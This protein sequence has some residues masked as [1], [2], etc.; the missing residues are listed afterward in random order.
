MSEETVPSLAAA[1]PLSATGGDGR[2]RQAA[3][4]AA[5][6][7]EVTPTSLVAYGSAGRLA[8]LGATAAVSR[9]VERLMAI[10][11]ARVLAVSVFLTDAEAGALQ[12]IQ[13]ACPDTRIVH[14]AI[15]RVEGHL[16]AFS[17]FASVDGEP[18]QVAP[19][20]LTANQGFDL[21][22]DLNPGALVEHPVAP[23]GYLWLAAE[24]LDEERS[25]ALLAQLPEL[26]GEFHKPRYFR[27]DTGICAHA[28]RGLVGCSACLQ[29]CPTGAIASIDKRIE[30]DPY[31]CQ[32]GGS[33]VSVCPSGAISYAYP[34]PADLL[35]RI[36]VMLDAYGRPGGGAPIL[37]VH[38]AEVGQAWLLEHGGSLPEHVLPLLVEEIGATGPD[39]W[40]SALAYGAASVLLLDHG[41]VPA[42]VRDA[43]CSQL[44]IAAALL[45]G[46][47]RDGERLALLRLEDLKTDRTTLTSAFDSDR[48]RTPDWPPAKHAPQTAKRERLRLALDHL[49]RG[50][51]LQPAEIALPEDASF[52]SVEV[53]QQGCTLCMACVAVCPASAILAGGERPELRFIEQ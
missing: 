5:A 29:V 9:V 44:R 4:A 31:L 52:G 32:G 22:L 21:V 16:G 45:D 11:Q 12:A 38:D 40:L 3:L 47:G 49:A 50:A 36:R 18:H 53:E 15:N 39:I 30:V 34:P 25:Q 1:L 37:L 6:A 46:L 26:V 13:T 19:S 20:I 27:L 35:A 8:V 7:V 14:A 43:L 51:P 24:A 42:P 41:G 23:P 48:T 17:L 28:R 33:C 2:A 10:D